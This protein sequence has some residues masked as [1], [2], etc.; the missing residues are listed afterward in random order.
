MVM[1]DAGGYEVYAAVQG[2]D[3]PPVVAVSAQGTDSTQWAAVAHRLTSCPQLI[4]YDR[5]GM[6][7]S[8]PRPAPNPPAPYRTFADEL[9]TMLDHLGI[10][11]AVVAVGHSFG[12]L[13]VRSFAA[14]RPDRVA[15]MVHA[16]GSLPG[17]VLWPG[18]GPLIDGS[19]PHATNIDAATGADDLA[20]DTLPDVPAVVLTRTPGRWRDPR[21][22]AA[23]DQAWS[24]NQAT[25]ARLCRAPLVTATDAGHDLPGQAPGLVAYAIDQVVLA[26]RTNAAR[27]VLDPIRVAN[28]G[29][30]A[31]DP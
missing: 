1:V 29:G 8:A 14:R 5:P 26:V 18:Y 3:N 31:V 7:R 2:G 10:T 28:V 17:M 16:D 27:V 24:D 12:S 30:T 25:L 19:G 15:G 23:V 9:A 6:G 11:T 13:I 22:D 21:A 20:R 4:T